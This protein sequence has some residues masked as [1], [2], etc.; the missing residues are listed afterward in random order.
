[1]GHQFLPYTD[2]KPLLALLNE[3][4]VTSPQAFAR[5]HWWSLFFSAYEYNLKF[6]DTLSHANADALS[7]LPLVVVPPETDTPPEV[8]LL[9]EH[10]CDSSVTAHDIQAATQKDPL[11]SKVLQ[12]VCRGWPDSNM[13]GTDLSP[14]FTR[15]AEL[16]LQDGCILWGSRVIVPS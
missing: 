8:I 3:H 9:M 4:H 5:I 6:R 12:Y 7:R 10:L 15:R 13:G 2:H 1:M 11:L 14:F 16:S